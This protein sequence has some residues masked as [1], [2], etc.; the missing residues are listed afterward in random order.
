[1]EAARAGMAAQ[2]AV[3]AAAVSDA[4]GGAADSSLSLPHPATAMAASKSGTKRDVFK[5]GSRLVIHYSQRSRCENALEHNFKIRQSNRS[6]P[7]I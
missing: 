7:A 1:M 5:F 3:E 4:A 6:M 2:A